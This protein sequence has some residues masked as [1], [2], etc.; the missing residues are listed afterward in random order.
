MEALDIS[1]VLGGV[2]VLQRKIENKMDLIEISRIGLTKDALINLSKYLSLPV[3]RMADI[4]PISEHT[5]Q[6]YTSKEHFN[7]IV[8]EQI[9]KIAEVVAKGYQVFEDKEKFISWI[10]QPNKTFGNRSPLS[11]FNS[12]F[13]TDMVLDE[14]GRIEHGVIS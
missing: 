11:L 12:S 9:L 4:I 2:N 14:L 8:S 1:D 13:G 6:K 10:N 5:I 3:N 7:R